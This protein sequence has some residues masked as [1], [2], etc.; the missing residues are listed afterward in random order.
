MIKSKS[1]TDVEKT[2]KKT[3]IG[4]SHAMISSKTMNKNRRSRYKKY[5]GQGK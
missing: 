1:N 2:K 5:R 3:S 4:G